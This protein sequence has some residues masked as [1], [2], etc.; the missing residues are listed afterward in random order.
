[1]NIKRSQTPIGSDDDPIGMQAF[2]SRVKRAAPELYAIV[3]LRQHLQR[4]AAS[5]WLT[6]DKYIERKHQIDLDAEALLAEIEGNASKVPNE[7]RDARVSAA[8]AMGWGIIE[9]ALAER[10][11]RAEKNGPSGTFETEMLDDASKR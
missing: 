8:H 3:K 7:E 6:F 5:G 1:M 4:A 11:A 9:Q 10:L 2:I